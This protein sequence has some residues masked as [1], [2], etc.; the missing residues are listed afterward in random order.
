VAARAGEAQARQIEAAEARAEAENAI[1]GRTLRAFTR[2]EEEAEAGIPRRRASFSSAISRA[3]AA[4]AL[5]STNPNA[6]ITNSL[7][8][9]RFMPATNA[10]QFDPGYSEAADVLSIVPGLSLESATIFGGYSSNSLP[11]S[12]RNGGE[13]AYG[14]Q[15]LGSDYDLGANAVIAYGHQGRR[16]TTR[17]T[18]MPSHVQ[19]SRIPEWST[20]D[21]H[22][23]F[24]SSR[25]LTPRI[26]LQARG[27]AADAGLEQFWTRP[28]VTR[29]V[30]VPASFS[31]LLEK[32]NAGEISND[33]FAAILTGSPVVD[34][35][36][37]SEQDLTR[38]LSASLGTGVSY[39]YSRRMTL[40][41]G[42]AA[43]VN[44]LLRD[45]LERSDPGLPYLNFARTTR[46]NA[47]ANYRLS[48][49]TRIGVRHV[50]AFAN[51]TFLHSV[52]HSPS[53]ELTQTLSR[54]WNYQ[55]AGGIGTIYFDRSRSAWNIDASTTWTAD[56]LLGY[57]SGEHHITLSAS[58]RVG[59]PLGFGSRS[60][61]RAN[62]MWA[63][64]PRFSPWGADAGI[65]FS[66]TD[67]G[68]VPQL[69]RGFSSDLYSAGLSRRLT[70]S[71]TLRSDYYYGD[72]SSPYSGVT[73]SITL[74]RLQMS[75]MWRPVEGR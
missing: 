4:G 12:F 9:S 51:S 42:A 44:R 7:S 61:A 31:E 36:G 18:Y 40:N 25:D 47:A 26:T 13:R 32:V 6:S 11:R 49:R 21:H 23:S 17:F 65:A 55:V 41:F 2:D 71:T 24:Q 30:D 5:T 33:E 39:A 63:W 74:H 64:Q 60:T 52:S 8:S 50:T 14:T 58:K 28:A 69:R 43:S 75:L 72:Y 10:G 27:N 45:R 16:S 29:R 57:T 1:V 73:S 56:G 38:V 46:A 34:D 70:P 66:R 59:D 67:V 22:L 48:S 37:G 62:L 19:R 35:P 3:A 68:N 15:N 53:V 20:T 54:H